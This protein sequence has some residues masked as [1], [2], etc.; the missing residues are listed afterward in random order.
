MKS[1][2]LLITLLLVG[3]SHFSLAM[4]NGIALCPMDSCL[5]AG[6]YVTAEDF[7]A[8]R[9]IQ[10]V[11]LESSNNKFIIPSLANAHTLTIVLNGRA[12]SYKPDSI[13]GYM[14]CGQK[15]RYYKELNTEK[16][17]AYYKIEE[18]GKLVVYSLSQAHNGGTPHLHHY[19]SLGLDSSIKP[20]NEP[21]LRNDF[22]D[23]KSFL[24]AIE[25]LKDKNG[26]HDFSLKDKEGHFTVIVLFEH[27]SKK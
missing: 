17:G 14:H 12:T 25:I 4:P 18:A 8:N 24:K 16:E 6:V 2:S 5:V 1:H 23:N 11:D 10:K 15:F 7:A 26:K 9:L 21:N 22:K 20:L 19:Y 13:Y 27:F 3:L